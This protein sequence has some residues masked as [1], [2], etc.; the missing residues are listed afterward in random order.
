MLITYWGFSSVIS[1]SMEDKPLGTAA[2]TCNR[3]YYLAQA[4][5]YR[6]LMEQAEL[7][8]LFWDIQ[9]SATLDTDCED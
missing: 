9:R 1:I 2:C 3:D 6:F 7:Q 5:N 8:A 4:A